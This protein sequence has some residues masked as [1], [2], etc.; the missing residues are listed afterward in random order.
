MLGI[1]YIDYDISADSVWYIVV[2]NLGMSIIFII[3]TFFKESRL[4]KAF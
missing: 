1:S 4:T 2:L 3:I